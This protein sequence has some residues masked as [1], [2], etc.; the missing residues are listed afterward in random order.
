M[1]RH[2]LRL[3]GAGGA[4]DSTLTTLN[5]NSPLEGLNFEGTCV[6]KI[7]AKCLNRNLRGAKLVQVVLILRSM[8]N[9]YVQFIYIKIV[10]SRDIKY[11]R[12]SPNRSKPLLTL[13]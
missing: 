12:S 9:L 1:R 2:N 7:L 6:L 10:G 3:P 11:Q 8:I 4:T 5:F 13:A